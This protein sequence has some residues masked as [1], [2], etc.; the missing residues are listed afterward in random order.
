MTQKI[1]EVIAIEQV[2][3]GRRVPA[4]HNGRSVDGDKEFGHRRTSAKTLDNTRCYAVQR[5]ATRTG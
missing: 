2:L 4:A 1:V 5:D 3:D